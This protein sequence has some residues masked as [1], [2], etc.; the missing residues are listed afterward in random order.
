MLA[1]PRGFY[2]TKMEESGRRQDV[3]REEDSALTGLSSHS[4]G[5]G[6]SD[7]PKPGWAGCGEANGK[8]GTL[9]PA[10]IETA[11]WQMRPRGRLF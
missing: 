10:L 6:E 11:F 3:R 5:L 8:N 4:D 9:R 1:E 2:F 7:E